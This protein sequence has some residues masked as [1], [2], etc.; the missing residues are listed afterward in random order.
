MHR[1]CVQPLILCNVYIEI[2][3]ITQFYPLRHAGGMLEPANLFL[4][5]YNGHVVMA[6]LERESVQHLY[7]AKTIQ[8]VD[9][10][11]GER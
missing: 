9:D 3:H 1:K 6:E 4:A 7:H 8:N 5:A 2:T 10:F 11:N